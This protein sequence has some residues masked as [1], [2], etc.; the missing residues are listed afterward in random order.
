[1]IVNKDLSISRL[2]T[3]LAIW[4]TCFHQGLIWAWVREVLFLD[5]GLI[6]NSGGGMA[7]RIKVLDPVLDFI[8]G[9][10]T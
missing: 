1:M 10:W 2:N 3:V 4:H 9:L 7:C 6:D 8:L 5:Q